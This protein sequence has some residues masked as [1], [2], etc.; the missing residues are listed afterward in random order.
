M[1]LEPVPRSRRTDARTS[2]EAGQSMAMAAATHRSL[3]WNAVRVAGP[4]GRFEISE[5]TGLDPY[6]VARRVAELVEQGLLR[7]VPRRV[8]ITP[9]GR[10]GGV[11]EV[12]A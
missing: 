11:W 5:L 10:E 9:S 3:I 2:K 4:S 8:E 12:T 7:R 6:Q 1:N